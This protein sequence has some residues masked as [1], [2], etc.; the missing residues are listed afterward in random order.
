MAQNPHERS[1]PSAILTYAHGA[2]DARPRQ[3]EQVELG[4]G[5]GADRD[6]LAALGG[7]ATSGTPK[8]A[9]WSTSGSAAAS[10]SP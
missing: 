7:A 10:S 3:V 5:D 6:Q 9:T 1:Q 4:H 2:V 8:P